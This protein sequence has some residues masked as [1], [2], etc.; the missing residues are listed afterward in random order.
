M[1]TNHYRRRFTCLACS[2]LLLLGHAHASAADCAAP[3]PEWEQFKHQMISVD[4]RVTDRKEA[5]QTTVSEAQVYGMFFALVANDRSSF[6]TLLTWTENN[7]AGGDLTVR[8][9]A[10]QWGQRPDQSWGILDDNSASDADLWLAYLLEQAGRHWQTPRYRALGRLLAARILKEE[11]AELPG[12]GLAL[13]PAPRGF[14]YAAANSPTSWKLNASYLPLQVLRGLET[15]HKDARWGQ[16]AHSAFAITVGS[17]PKGY[18]ADWIRYSA[19]SGFSIDSD[20]AEQGRGGYNAIRVYLWTGMLADT[21]PERAALLKALA[22]MA[23]LTEQL[24]YPPEYVRIDNGITT[25]SA[26]SGFSAALL[27]FF[28]ASRAHKA[29][30]HQ[31]QR[32]Q[33]RPPQA[34]YDRV[35][36]LFAGGWL[37]RRYTFDANGSLRLNSTCKP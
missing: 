12:L 16:L 23:T 31:Q 22:P 10:W 7:L 26:G 21:V 24:G 20:G 34:Y 11:S 13:L 18:A 35:L 32:L 29:F 30:D 37:E 36:S 33:A 5:Q 3:W 2:C 14:A 1:R 15:A 4:G 28:Q 17:A 25:G 8:L 19:A 9:P 6:D 27:P